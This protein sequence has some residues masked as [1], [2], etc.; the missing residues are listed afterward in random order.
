MEP[1]NHKSIMPSKHKY[2]MLFNYKSTVPCK[3]KYIVL[4]CG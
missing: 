3:Y 1:C 2:V 4:C